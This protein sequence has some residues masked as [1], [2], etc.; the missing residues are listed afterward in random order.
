[1][2]FGVSVFVLFF[3]ELVPPRLQLL[4]RVNFITEKLFNFSGWKQEK[5]VK[6]VSGHHVEIFCVFSLFFRKAN[7]I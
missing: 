2:D 3:I 6:Y 1:M 4:S 5:A 7:R